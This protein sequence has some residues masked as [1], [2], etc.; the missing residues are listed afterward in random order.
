MKPTAPALD[1]NFEPEWKR[2][3]RLRAEADRA[4]KQKEVEEMKERHAKEDAERARKAEL[5]NEAIANN[6]VPVKKTAQL[7]TRNR[8]QEDDMIE[9]VSS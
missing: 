4:R 1:S 3:E 2:Q 9:K 6:A 5:A 8:T 7:K